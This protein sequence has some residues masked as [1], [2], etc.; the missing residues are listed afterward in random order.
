MEKSRNSRNNSQTSA[1]FLLRKQKNEDNKGSNSNV[2]N[3]TANKKNVPTGFFAWIAW[4]FGIKCKSVKTE[5]QKSI[6]EYNVK[7]ITIKTNTIT[8]KDLVTVLTQNDINS[9][10]GELSDVTNIINAL[11]SDIPYKSQMKTYL[12]GLKAENLQLIYNNINDPQLL[13]TIE[14]MSHLDKNPESLEVWKKI[15]HNLTVIKANFNTFITNNEITIE[16]KYTKIIGSKEVSKSDLRSI[17][18]N[19]QTAGLKKSQIG[20]V[21]EGTLSRLIIEQDLVTE[22]RIKINDEDSSATQE[23]YTLINNDP[24]YV[25]V[26]FEKEEYLT[27]NDIHWTQEAHIP[28][29]PNIKNT[30]AESLTDLIGDEKPIES[31][32]VKEKTQLDNFLEETKD[33]I[34]ETTQIVHEKIQELIVKPLDNVKEK[35]EVSYNQF[36]KD[37]I[38][39]S[40]KAA[41]DIIKTLTSKNVS[42]NDFV[43]QIKCIRNDES[44]ELRKEIIKQIKNYNTDTLGHIETLYNNTKSENISNDL[45]KALIQ[46]IGI[47]YTEA[48]SLLNSTAKAALES[49]NYSLEENITEDDHEKIV[50]ID[51][52]KTETKE[53]EKVPTEKKIEKKVEIQKKETVKNVTIEK[54]EEESS[55]FSGLNN[56]TQLVTEKYTEYTKDPVT[57]FFNVFEKNSL[58]EK[59]VLNMIILFEQASRDNINFPK[60]LE[61]IETK[62]VGVL[63]NLWS[64]FGNLQLNSKLKIKSDKVKTKIENNEKLTKTDKFWLNLYSRFQNTQKAIAREYKQKTET[65]ISSIG[66]VSKKDQIDNKKFNEIFNNFI[67]ELKKSN[68]S[69]KAELKED[70]WGGF[71]GL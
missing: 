65:S 15:K 66:I 41:T 32:V 6:S 52:K 11:S 40:E 57:D 9:K 69:K 12:Q 1:E 18:L 50:T 37:Y 30:K 54:K 2:T 10:K 68:S 3:L 64:F 5:N 39:K 44:G 45:K 7:P 23:N 61:D 42:V 36:H 35:I 14:L 71:F 38:S 19:Q 31:I 59:N 63:I 53:E 43:Q 4:L 17:L 60:L 22:K 56:I 55:W 13:N 51:E 47:S 20:S 26:E 8:V 29:N 27:F 58:N 33:K 34:E 24:E 49:N 16:K 25:L 28:A 67:Q 48:I 62:E 46:E 21:F 70:S